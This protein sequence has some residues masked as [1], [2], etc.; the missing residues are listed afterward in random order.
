MIVQHRP[1]QDTVCIE[2]PYVSDY[3]HY[4]PTCNECV[5]KMYAHVLRE[6]TDKKVNELTKGTL[7]HEL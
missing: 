5:K 3:N 7:D 2:K 6:E 1:D 4:P